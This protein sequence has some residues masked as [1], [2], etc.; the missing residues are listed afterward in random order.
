MKE[1]GRDHEPFI[2]WSVLEVPDAC[3]VAKDTSGTY[4]LLGPGGDSGGEL[5]LLLV[6]DPG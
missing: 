6:F 2:T 1:S 4:Q 5:I 3:G